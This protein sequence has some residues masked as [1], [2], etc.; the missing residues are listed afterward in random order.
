MMKR[1]GAAGIVAALALTLSACLLTPGKFV[2]ALDLRKDGHFTFAYKGELSL[3][4][5]T[6]LAAMDKGND[7]FKPSACYDYDTP[8]D[9]AA[10]AA[11]AAADAAADKPGD[12]AKATDDDTF[13]DPKERPCTKEEL[14][15]QKVAWEQNRKET[16]EK[17][18]KDL[19]EM[20]A[21]LG[22][23]DP[24]D[25][26]SIEEFA[27][28]LR[29]QAGWKLVAYK[30]NGLFDVDYAIAGKADHDFIFPIIEKFPTTNT[31]VQVLRRSDGTVRIDAPGFNAN[32]SGNP[33]GQAMGMGMLGAMGKGDMP[34]PPE[35]DGVFTVTTNGQV[36]ANNT[37]EGPQADPAGQ[38]LSWNVNVRS[39]SA[40][41]ALIKLAN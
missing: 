15:D 12:E 37:D 18:K 24:T 23:L 10:D 32:A 20:K 35:M 21:A 39:T 11:A 31:F 22:G 34:K 1:I 33:M 8:A 41:T 5:I 2:S 29:R 9:T 26:K 14:A 40:P 36:L 7:T 3:Y 17:K 38:K 6:Q 28:R 30:G 16:A 4:G 27:A 19:E 13:G 25:P